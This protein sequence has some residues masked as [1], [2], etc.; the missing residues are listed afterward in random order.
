MLLDASRC[1]HKLKFRT[2][3]EIRVRRGYDVTAA[4]GWQ[5]RSRA[6]FSWRLPSRARALKTAEGRARHQRA[7]KKKKKIDDDEI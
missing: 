3:N 7:K 5:R 2:S 6:G 4:D 1:H